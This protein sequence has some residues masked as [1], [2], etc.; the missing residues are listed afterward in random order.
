MGQV[1]EIRKRGGLEN[2]KFSKFK[3]TR[4]FL[5][6]QIIFLSSSSHL[7]IF[8]TVLFVEFVFDKKTEGP[9]LY[10]VEKKMLKGF[11]RGGNYLSDNY[12]IS[13]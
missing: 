5:F 8:S 2:H 10:R 7:T 11:A 1:G 13:N 9:A 12:Y 3:E 4:L 6:Q